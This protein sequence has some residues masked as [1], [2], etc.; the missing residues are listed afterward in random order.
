MHVS[1]EDAQA[2]YTW[3]RR[4]LPTEAEWEYAARGGKK[5]KIY[6]WG[7]FIENLSSNVNSWEVEFPV[8]NTQADGY[9]KSAP[10]K[11]FPPNNFWFV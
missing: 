11:T 3:A 10:V 5:D 8:S 7:D 6:F 4:C 1:F 2:Y 9:E